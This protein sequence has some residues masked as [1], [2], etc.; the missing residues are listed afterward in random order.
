MTKVA[1][2]DCYTDEPSGFGV[3]PFVGVYPRY[4]AGYVKQ[5]LPDSEIIY[6]TID[7]IR[8]FDPTFNHSLR[9]TDDTDIFVCNQTKND[10]RKTL[11]ESE[12]IYVIV[13]VQVP[14][15]YLSAVPG[16]FKEITTLLTKHGLFKEKGDKKV[17][18]KKRIVFAGPAMSDFGS[19][20]QG[21]KFAEDA[22][23]TLKRNFE[24]VH[25]MPEAFFT[26]YTK[27]NDYALL[28]ASIVGS[29]FPRPYIVELETSRGC[30]RTKNCSFC[31]EP[32]A[33][34]QSFRDQEDIV[35]EMKVFYDLGVR[36]FRFGRQTCFFSYKKHS[37]DELEKLFKLTWKTCPEIEVLHIDNVDPIR[38]V[39]P[40][41]KKMTELTTKY[42]TAGNIAPFG[43]ET[44]DE[45]V[46][47]ANDLNSMP[48][49]SIRAIEII[50]NIGKERGDNGMP[51]F[52]PG[53]NIIFGLIDESKQTH[54]ENMTYLQKLVENDWWARRINIRQVVPFYGTKLYKEAK[55]K[56]IKKN[57]KRYFAWR[58]DIRENIE[59]QLMPKM[60]PKGLII[61]NCLAETY[62]QGVTYFRQLGTYP[63]I[64][65]VKG[66]FD[67]KVFYNINIIDYMLRSLVGE[68]VE[69]SQWQEKSI[70]TKRKKNLP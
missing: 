68:V 70:I 50:N 4:I 25:I 58:R 65:G 2:I 24:N 23:A 33:D 20:V 13:G 43:I 12:H 38:V 15:K 3:P 69:E 52:L 9:K 11:A 49:V 31:T 29:Q 35:A 8:Y 63:I 44:F 42:C 46:V 26:D 47:R 60:F 59:G 56:F 32:L 55:N 19:Q 45:K 67:L 5:R 53:I 64:I 37:P 57:R 41:G 14:G 30:Y 18:S 40:Q 61:K 51:K 36:H 48:K 7:D 10:V 21:G 54:E 22:T 1:I 16:T 34:K 6:L 62:K 27:I 66:K 39:T 17:H 28:G